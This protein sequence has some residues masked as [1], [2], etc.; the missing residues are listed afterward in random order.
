MKK[1][2]YFNAQRRF[3]Q[4]LQFIHGHPLATAG[5]GHADI[6]AGLYLS[7]GYV[8]HSLLTFQPEMIDVEYDSNLLPPRIEL[9]RAAVTIQNRLDSERDAGTYGF[10]LAYLGHQ[11][12]DQEMVERGLGVLKM[13]S[14]SDDP[15]VSLLQKIWG[16]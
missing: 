14:D 15:F 11:L 5:L 12:H 2:N 3:N 8:L 10:L 9:V 6:G 13:Y 7:A 4:A 16:E 1:G